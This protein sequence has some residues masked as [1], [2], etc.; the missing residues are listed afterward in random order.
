MGV[1]T[2]NSEAICT[3]IRIGDSQTGFWLHLNH[4]GLV[5]NATRQVARLYVNG[6]VPNHAELALGSRV[7]Y[8]RLGMHSVVTF[9]HRVTQIERHTPKKSIQVK[10]MRKAS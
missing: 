7:K 1:Q 8:Y 2:K 9:K 6:L 5:V 4:G 3:S 10:P